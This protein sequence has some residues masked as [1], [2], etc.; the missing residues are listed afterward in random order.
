[1]EQPILW[2]I[3]YFSCTIK[4]RLC[5]PPVA[6]SY[7]PTSKLRAGDIR[8][9]FPVHDVAADQEMQA[10]EGGVKQKNK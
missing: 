8:L 2:G 9:L 3:F 7:A 6:D 1:M 4:L 10:C 5:T